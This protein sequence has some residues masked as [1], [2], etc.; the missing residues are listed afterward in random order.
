MVVLCTLDPSRLHGS[1][2]DATFL[3]GSVQVLHKSTVHTMLLFILC[4]CI[5]GFSL[6]YELAGGVSGNSHIQLHCGL[7]ISSNGIPES[8]E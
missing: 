3:F 1:S 7:N 5:S 8:Y 2:V 6:V 4:T